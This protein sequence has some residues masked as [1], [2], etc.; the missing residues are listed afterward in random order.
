MI[1]QLYHKKQSMENE[2]AEIE[3]KERE[4]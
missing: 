2:I 1:E 4:F 3:E